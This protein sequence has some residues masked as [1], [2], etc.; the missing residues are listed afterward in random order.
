MPRQSDKAGSG[1]I[2]PR[3][4][5]GG[6]M[7]V[8]RTSSSCKGQIIFR[9]RSCRRCDLEICSRESATDYAHMAAT[10]EPFDA[11]QPQAKSPRKRHLPLPPK[12]KRR[13]LAIA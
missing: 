11:H 10:L 9:T 8:V 4:K 2:C 13:I 12:R 3:P 7:R 5:C 1:F 6:K